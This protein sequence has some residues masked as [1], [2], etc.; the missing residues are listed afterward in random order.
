MDKT[1][2]K[3]SGAAKKPTT[4]KTAVP[5]KENSIITTAKEVVTSVSN[6][7]P[8]LWTSKKTT[9]KKK[10]TPKKKTPVTKTTPVKKTPVAKKATPV[11]KA[12]PTK[13]FTTRK[14]APAPKTEVMDQKVT[15]VVETK[16]NKKAEKKA[17]KEKKVEAKKEEVKKDK[18]VETKT[19]DKWIVSLAKFLAWVKAKHLEEVLHDLMTEKEIK[20]FAERIE[21]L[22]LLSKKTPQREIAKKLWISVTTVSRW[23]KV[24]QSWK[25]KIQKYL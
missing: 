19:S 5:K 13:K 25:G 18:K 23:S 7:L 20:E 24:L 4:K 11:K 12:K 15:P 3:K 2:G 8:S 1:K 9:V 17:K 6:A 10:T 21:I 16:N 14:I 22:K